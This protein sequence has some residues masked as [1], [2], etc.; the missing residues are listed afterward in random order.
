MDWVEVQS[1]PDTSSVWACFVPA[2]KTG[3]IRGDFIIANDKDGRPDMD[4]RWVVNGGI[5]ASTYDNTGWEEFLDPKAGVNTKT[6]KS[7][8]VPFAQILCTKDLL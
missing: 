6:E 2:A 5:F 4:D 7:Q 3:K 8:L 1:K